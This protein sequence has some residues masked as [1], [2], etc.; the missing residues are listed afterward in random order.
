MLAPLF[1]ERAPGR[2]ADFQRPDD[3]ARI[4]R[5]DKIC[6][7]GV[8]FEQTRIERFDTLFGCECFK[9][10][11]QRWVGRNFRDRPAFQQGGDVL[12]RSADQQR[13]AIALV[14]VVNRGIGEALILCQR[15]IFVWRDHVNQVMD[16]LLRA[17]PAWVSPCRCPSRGKSGGCRR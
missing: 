17:A 15:Q 7:V 10:G 8:E 16:G 1:A 3:P 12:S 13:Q 4:A 11:A 6:G 9:F 2:D 5:L 14:N